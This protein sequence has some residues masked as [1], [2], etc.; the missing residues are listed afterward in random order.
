MAPPGV[1]SLWD[2]QDHL[3][4]TPALLITRLRPQEAPKGE[5]Q[6]MACDEVAMLQKNFMQIEIWRTRVGS[7][8]QE[9][10]THQAKSME[11]GPLTEGLDLLQPEEEER[12]P[13][14]GC[15]VKT[16]TTKQ[17]R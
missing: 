17:V 9:Y 3:P 8:W 6:S 10:E 12:G 7:R 14:C 15:L 2:T 11:T 16:W 1:G 13:G 4:P 5:V